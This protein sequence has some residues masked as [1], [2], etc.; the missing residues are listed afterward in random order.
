MNAEQKPETTTPE[1]PAAAVPS[2][3]AQIMQLL[4][5]YL[6]PIG[7]GLLIAI[8]IIVGYG[9]YKSNKSAKSEEAAAA[10]MQARSLEDIQRVAKEY[11]TTPAGPAALL[12]LANNY[13]QS[14]QI[15]MA[16]TTYDQFITEYPQHIMVPSAELGK[17]YCIEAEGDFN[18]AITAFQ[19]FVTNNPGYFMAP[20]AILSQGRCLEQLGRYDDAIILYE[21]FIAENPESRWIPHAKTAIQYVKKSRRAH[22]K[23]LDVPTAPL[24]SM[25]PATGFANLPATEAEVIEAPAAAETAATEAPAQPVSE[26]A[27]ATDAA[28]AE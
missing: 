9:M 13:L 18:G 10:L 12:G 2:D 6:L 14:G 26:A 11:K 28:P 8:V 27:P 16:K 3:I 19:A 17:A 22:E 4:K 15:Q 7:V 1:T 25:Q 20:E 5:D 21:N 23:G 24:I